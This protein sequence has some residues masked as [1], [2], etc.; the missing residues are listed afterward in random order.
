[1][2]QHETQAVSKDLEAADQGVPIFNDVTEHYHNIIGVPNQKADL[3]TMPAPL[4]WF[5]Y[6]LYGVMIV[7]VIAFAVGM[8][9]FN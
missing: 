5:G 2:K 6:F 1:M 9:F 3:Q 4:R 8:I 7:F